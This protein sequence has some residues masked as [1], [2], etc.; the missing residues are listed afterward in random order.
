MIFRKNLTSTVSWQNQF[1]VDFIGPLQDKWF[2]LRKIAEELNIQFP[3]ST[4]WHPEEVKRL[5]KK[6]CHYRPSE[7]RHSRYKV[8]PRVCHK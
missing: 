7:A 6:Y 2:S 1:V 5:L 8:V 4:P 3:K